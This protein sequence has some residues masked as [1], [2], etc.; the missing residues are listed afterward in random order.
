VL[1]CAGAIGSPQLLLLSGIGSPDHLAEVGVPVRHEL[2]GVGENLQD[3]PVIPLMFE[4]SDERTLYGADN[5][6]HLAEWLLRRSGKLTSTV[7]EAVAFVRTRPGLPAPDIQFHA[8]AAFF[9]DH[10]A[11][12]FEGHAYLMAP[13]LLTPKSRGWVRLRSADPAAKPRILTNSLAE[14]DDVASMVAGMELAREIA[15]REPLASTVLREL[16]PGSDVTDLEASLRERVE[17]LYHPAGSCRMGAAD[18]DLAVVDPELCVRGLEGVRVIDASIMPVI[19]GGNTN[20]PTIMVAERAA[21]LIRGRVP[22]A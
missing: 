12:E 14:A 1:V 7:A 17:L 21:D 18:D 16:R 19:P 20:A 3:H 2:R 11:T 9:E 4:V 10:G 8:G 22:V 6:R 15:R 5:P 13:T